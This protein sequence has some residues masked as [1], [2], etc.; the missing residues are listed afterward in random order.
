MGV[1]TIMA[2]DYRYGG[3]LRDIVWDDVAGTVSG[4]H[5]EVPSIQEILDGPIPVNLG[6]CADPAIV[7]GSGLPG[8]LRDVEPTP[9]QKP[10][11]RYVIEADG[12]RRP[13][14]AGV[15]YLP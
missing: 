7:R 14:V 11:T 4:E 9:R 1:H 3:K 5:V 2:P 15:D 13:A 12:A 6:G 10:V 8:V